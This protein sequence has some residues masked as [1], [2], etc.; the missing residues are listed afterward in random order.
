[1]C[2]VI[3]IVKD[4]IQVLFMMVG[5][6]HLLEMSVTAWMTCVHANML[7]NKHYMDFS[8][9]GGKSLK[10][11]YTANRVSNCGWLCKKHKKNDVFCG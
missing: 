9:Q 2:D 6:P 4:Q 7:K 8:F 1:M 11:L 3:L 5:F 10:A